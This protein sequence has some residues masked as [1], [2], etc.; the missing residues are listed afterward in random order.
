MMVQAGIEVAQQN[1]RVPAMA[2]LRE[3]LQVRAPGGAVWPGRGESAWT[4]VSQTGLR[5]HG[6][7]IEARVW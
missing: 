4:A 3:R 2:G 6:T 5:L 7:V 1:H